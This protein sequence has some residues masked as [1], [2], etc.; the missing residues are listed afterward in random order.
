MSWHGLCLGWLGLARAGGWLCWVSVLRPPS[1]SA[2]C[3]LSAMQVRCCMSQPGFCWE[4]CC[5][6][7]KKEKW[8]KMG[9]DVAP[10]LTTK[11]WAVRRLLAA[12]MSFWNACIPLWGALRQKGRMMPGPGP[13][14]PANRMQV[15]PGPD[16]TFVS[17]FANPGRPEDPREWRVCCSRTADGSHRK[18]RR[19]QA[20]RRTGKGRAG[21][22]DTHMQQQEAGDRGAVPS[23]QSTQGEIK[24]SQR[25]PS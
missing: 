21:Q 23:V 10:M 5:L 1:L 16:P 4:L 3:H 13:A 22:A 12:E 2:S 14:A 18:K 20:G 6:R 15:A 7:A 9:A 8:A 11:P 24:A 19:E 25:H 17:S